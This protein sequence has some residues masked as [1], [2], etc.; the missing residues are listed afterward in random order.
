MIQGVRINIS[1][2]LVV[3]QFAVAVVSDR[4]KVLINEIRRSE[5]AATAVKTY[6]YPTV[7]P[8]FRKREQLTHRALILS[9]F[10]LLSLWK[11]FLQIS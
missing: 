9:S 8:R 6:H 7:G 10:H 1:Q 2:Q 4:R 5:T 3:V 11:S